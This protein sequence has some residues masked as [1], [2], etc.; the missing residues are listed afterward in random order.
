MSPPTA[1]LLEKLNLGK[2]SFLVAAIL[3][4]MSDED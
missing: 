3:I 4:E 1:G 2:S